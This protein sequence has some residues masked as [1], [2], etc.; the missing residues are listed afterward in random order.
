MNVW[1]EL[2]LD[3]NERHLV[4]KLIGNVPELYD[5]ANGK[6]QNGLYPNIT[7]GTQADK[8]VDH[9]SKI[10]HINS[11]DD[12]TIPSIKSR[13][14]KVPL[15]FWFTLNHGSALPLLALQYHDVELSLTLRKITDLYTVIETDITDNAFGKRVKPHSNNI[16]GTTDGAGIEFFVTN[17]SIADVSGSNRSFKAFNINTKVEV[18]YIF[19]DEEERKRFALFEHQYLI[20]QH[21]KKREIGI[22]ANTVDMDI[23]SSNPIKYIVAVTKRNDAEK[24]ND[25]NNYTNWIYEDIPPYSQ[26]YLHKTMY[27]DS[28][29]ATNPNPFFSIGVAG[30]KTYLT[31]ESD[32][33]NSLKNNIISKAKI[34]F[35]GSDRFKEIDY[36]Y[37]EYQQPLNYFKKNN[38]R[39]IYV[40][41]FSLDPLKEQPSGACNFSSINKVQFN[42]TLNQPPNSYYKFDINVYLVSYN[43][44]KIM[45]GTGGIVYAI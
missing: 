34:T 2:N 12:S 3:N 43:I 38:K 10:I 22:T 28:T 5:P 30:H 14:I 8:Y 29:N 21:K 41:S 23:S 13:K 4:D 31:N 44:L 15:N 1:N 20:T 32:N 36:R 9:H 33:S 45:S 11:V 37:F 6:G 35:N 16:S 40:Y 27:Y 25:F 39:G 18:D 7:S 17:T 42:A 19:L 24:R 26:E